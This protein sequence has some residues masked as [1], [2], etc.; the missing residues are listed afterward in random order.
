MQRCVCGVLHFVCL[1]LLFSPL[2]IS[3]IILPITHFPLLISLLPSSISLFLSPLF[4]HRMVYFLVRSKML[5]ISCN[6]L[7]KWA[8]LSFWHEIN[9]SIFARQYLWG[10]SH[11][12]VLT[13][14]PP[15]QAMLKHKLLSSSSSN[16]FSPPPPHLHC[17]G[18]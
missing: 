8:S 1:S 6:L 7:N 17:S 13:Q 16:S 4:S 9:I 5:W 15:W 3:I 11:K 18:F 2:L 14:H 12:P 10:S